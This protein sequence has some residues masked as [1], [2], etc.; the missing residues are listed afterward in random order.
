MEFP[1]EIQMLIKDYLR[2]MTRPDWRQ[3][4]FITRHYRSPKARYGRLT[5]NEFELYLMR[6]YDLD[7]RNEDEDEDSEFYETIKSTANSYEHQYIKND[8]HIYQMRQ[9]Q[10]EYEKE[11]EDYGDYL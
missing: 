9:N 1:V 2:P 10:Y 11:R 3:G 8:K 6:C 7:E 4:S 5:F